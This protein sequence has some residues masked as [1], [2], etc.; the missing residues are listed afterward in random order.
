MSLKKEL[1]KQEE[2][3]QAEIRKMRMPDRDNLEMFGIVQQLHGSD[4][5]R[6]FCEDGKERMCRIPGKLRKSVWMRERD[7]VIIRLWDFQPIKA[8]I[9][10]R[11]TGTQVEHLKRK[12]VLTNLPL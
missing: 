1:E 3:K 2:K 8:D 7:I 4:Q 5:I 9:I 10:W 11:Y 6:I 12:G